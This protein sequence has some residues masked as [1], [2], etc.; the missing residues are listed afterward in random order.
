MT[1]FNI[2]HFKV[3]PGMEREFLLAHAPGKVNWPGLLRGTI[4]ET[5]DGRFSL[6]GEWKDV[7]TLRAAM[8]HMLATLESFRHTLIAGERGVT[9]AFSGPAVLAL[10]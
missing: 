5:G 9:D 6:I 1:T 8:P 7:Q 2:V 10:A 3:K 4:I